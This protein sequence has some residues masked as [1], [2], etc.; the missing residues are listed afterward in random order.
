MLQEMQTRNYSERT[1][2]CYLL[3]IKRLSHYFNCSPDRLSI[4][5]VKTYLHYC[6]THNQSSAVTINQMISAVKI[7]FTDVLDRKWEPLKIKR[8]RREKKLPVIFSKQEIALL[9]DHVRN[10]KHKSIFITAYSAGLRLNEVRLLKPNN[11]DSDRMQ[12]RVDNGKG[13]KTRLTLLS[14]NVLNQLRE[15]YKKYRPVAYLFEG[16]IPG[17]PISHR[18]IQK[19]FGDCITKAGITKAVSFHSLR[20]SFATHLLEQGTN[21]RLIQ[22]LLG[23]NSLKTTSVYL[24]LS[25]FDPKQVNSPFDNLNDH[26]YGQPQK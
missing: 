9:L 10:L 6:V 5:Q 11:I 1:I 18:T 15:Y 20:H 21:L 19:V 26:Q 16:R 25:C 4:E 2:H 17:V 24:H 14:P 12:I 22:Q 23:H 3:C 13:K 8:P 7:F